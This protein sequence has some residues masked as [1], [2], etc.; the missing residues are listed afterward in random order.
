MNIDT[1]KPKEK[2]SGL[3]RNMRVSATITFCL[4]VLSI[5][6][7]ILIYLALSDIANGEPNQTLEWII[8]GICLV[9]FALFVISAFVTLGFLIRSWSKWN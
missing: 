5:L 6:A 9:S 2:G 1:S 8:V 7:L 4:G 3:K